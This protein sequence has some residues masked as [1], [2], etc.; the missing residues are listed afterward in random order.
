M[1]LQVN[2]NPHS[3][4]KYLTLKNPDI[5]LIFKDPP[6]Q[7]YIKAFKKDGDKNVTY[8]LVTRD[9]DKLLVTGLPIKDNYLQ[10]QIKSASII[11]SFI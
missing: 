9:D 11:H 1:N 8:L 4:K 3:L 10:M 2:N 7:E 5:K 6:K